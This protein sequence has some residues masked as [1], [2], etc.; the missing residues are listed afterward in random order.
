[1]EVT[2]NNNSHLNN[3]EATVNLEATNRIR[4]TLTN[5]SLQLTQLTILFSS[6]QKIGTKFS[7]FSPLRSLLSPSL[8]TFVYCAPFLCVL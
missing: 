5:Y 4:S 7:V 3:T 2:S 1:M 8:S 6:R